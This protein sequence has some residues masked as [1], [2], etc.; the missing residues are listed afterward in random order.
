MSKSINKK[1]KGKLIGIA[2][3]LILISILGIAISSIS[4]QCYNNFKEGKKY[5]DKKYESL[6]GFS[7]FALVGTI[8]LCIIGLIIF[9]TQVI[10]KKKGS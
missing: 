7:I 9:F 8:L 3:L 1:S 4:V 2:I 10:K 6:R 5:D